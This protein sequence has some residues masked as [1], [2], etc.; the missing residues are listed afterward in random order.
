MHFSLPRIKRK[1][2]Q[3]GT[4]ET[5][6]LRGKKSD[7]GTQPYQAHISHHAPQANVIYAITVTGIIHI[8]RVQN[9]RG[10]S[11]DTLADKGARSQNDGVG[12]GR[13]TRE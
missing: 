7:G 4:I 13:Q 9:S 3:N 11:C 12:H 10:S 1:Y 6:E 5:K 8:L 2:A